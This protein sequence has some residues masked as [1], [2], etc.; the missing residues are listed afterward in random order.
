MIWS[1]FTFDRLQTVEFIN[2]PNRVYNVALIMKCN[3]IYNT[4]KK[5]QQKK[6]YNSSQCCTQFDQKFKF[7]I[8][9]RKKRKKKTGPT[10]TVCKIVCKRTNV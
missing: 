7:K 5:N 1:Q 6:N 2:I 10:N 4:K 9:V 3:S 8:R